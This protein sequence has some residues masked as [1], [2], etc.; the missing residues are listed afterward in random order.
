[1]KRCCL[2]AF[3]LLALLFLLPAAGSY[4]ADVCPLE[5]SPAKTDL[6]NGAFRLEIR[7]ENRIEDGG[8]FTAGLFLED[9]YDAVQIKALAPGSTVQM[10]GTVFTVQEIVIH[11]ADNPDEENTYEVYPVEEYFGYLVFIPNEDGTFSALIDDWVP[12]TPVGEIRVSL[13]LPD[14]FT[15]ISITAAE[16]D[17]PA[18]ADAFL[19]DLDMFGGF[20][21]WNTSCIIEDGVLVNITHASYPWGPEEYWPGE[22]EES[23]GEIPVWQFCHGNPD[24]LETAVITGSTLDCEAGP[25]PY[26]ITKEEAEELRTLAMYGMVTGLENDE[27][28]T[29]NTWLYAFETPDGDYIMTVELYRGLLVGSDGMY[30]YEIRANGD[31]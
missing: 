8:Y 6:T 22:A 31:V 4:A 14:R 25:V 15:Y 17:E 20:V 18:N 7:D 21:P 2:M 23:S 10:N 28:V 9:C 26:A 12:V 11:E 1:M 19:E 3:A 29:G 5:I 16:E 30:H 24:L 27:M 13:P